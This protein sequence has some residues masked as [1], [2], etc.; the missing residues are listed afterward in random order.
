MELNK[1]FAELIGILLGDGSINIYPSNKYSTYY[2]VKV[3]FNSNEEAYVGYVSDLMFKTLN[4]KPKRYDRKN[5]DTSELLIFK[6]SVA[7][8]L[9]SIGLKKSPKWN[10]AVIPEKFMK[11]RLGKYVLRG[12]FDTDGSVVLANNNGTLYPRLEMKICPSPMQ[13]QI[14]KLLNEYNLNYNYYN[15][16]KGKI[17]IQMNGK[18]ALKIWTSKIGFSNSKHIEKASYFLN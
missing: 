13:S 15:I 11:K 10:R 12:Y 17:R 2:R 9:L 8:K 6:K 5:E 4:E 3:S 1:D 14:L 16:G 7:N 18:K